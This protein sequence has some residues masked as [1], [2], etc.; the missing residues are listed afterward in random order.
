MK[1]KTLGI[2][3]G[4]RDFF[5]DQ[6]ISEGRNDILK[7]FSSMGITAIMPDEKMTRLG[8]VETWQDV[9][10]CAD[11]LRTHRD[12]IDGILVLLPNFGTEKSIADTIRRAELDVPIL[13]QAY[14]DAPDEFH[15]ERTIC[16][17]MDFLF[18]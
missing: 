4:N 3:V 9:K 5:P 1:Q 7:L 11:L 10:V 14:P 13:I 15:L 16:C 8:A 17:S 2:L 18:R 12:E 6:L